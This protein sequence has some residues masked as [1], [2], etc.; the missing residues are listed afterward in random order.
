MKQAKITKDGIKLH[1]SEKLNRHVSIPK[2]YC[3]YCD[4]QEVA[5]DEEIANQGLCYDC[6]DKI[7]GPE[8]TDIIGYRKGE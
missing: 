8:N 1:W 2:K 7:N 4:C 5:E 6:Y 3:E